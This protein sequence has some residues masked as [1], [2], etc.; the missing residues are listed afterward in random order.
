MDAVRPSSVFQ[1]LKYKWTKL[2]AERRFVRYGLVALNVLLLITIAW[3]TLGPTHTG[4]PLGR[5]GVVAAVGNAATEPLDQL[6]SADIAEQAAI[7]TGLPETLAVI[8]QADTVKSDQSIAPADTTVIAKPQLVATPFKSRKDIKDYIV[9]PGDTVASIASK[10]GV[11]SDSIIWSNG[12]RGNVV[13]TGVTLAIPPVNG[14]VYTVAPGDT[15]DDLA[16]KFRANKDLLITFNDIEITG[17]KSGDRILIPNGLQPAM[18]NYLV[19]QLVWGPGNG[20]DYGFCT[21]HVAN[22]RIAIGEPLPTNLGNAVSWYRNALANG[23][24]VGT[25]PKAGAVLWHVDTHIAGGLGHVGFVERVNDDG[26]I[27]VSDMNY[28]YRGKVTYRTILPSEFG[29]YRFIY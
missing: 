6:S 8:N 19:L 7:A 2:M 13:Q 25:T 26:S 14:I 11:T 18:T 4:R 22:R 24:P 17:L 23:M 21:W 1:R 12:L 16:R 28:P 10:F 9:Q 29:N 27:L 5:Q 15:L 20:Y 3:L